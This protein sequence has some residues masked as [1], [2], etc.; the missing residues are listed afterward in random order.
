M[1][2]RCHQVGWVRKTWNQAEEIVGR[3]KDFAFLKDAAELF[4]TCKSKGT[5]TKN[6]KDGLGVPLPSTS[7]VHVG[8]PV[9]LGGDA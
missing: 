6:M 4:M 3:L 5:G 8:L 2:G 7:T 1:A 9:W